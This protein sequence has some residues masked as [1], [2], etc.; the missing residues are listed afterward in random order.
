MR[1]QLTFDDAVVVWIGR[2]LGVP[3]RRLARRFDVDSRRLYEVWMLRRHPQSFAEAKRI[4]RALFPQRLADTDFA[5]HRQRRRWS[6]PGQLDLFED[7]ADD[8]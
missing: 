7:N 4:Y 6:I 8:H 2:W 3:T 5:E 1:R